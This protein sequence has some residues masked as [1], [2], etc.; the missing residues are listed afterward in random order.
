MT[1]TKKLSGKQVFPSGL[2][3]KKALSLGFLALLL[4]AGCCATLAPA[5]ATDLMTTPDYKPCGDDDDSLYKQ[6]QKANQAYI[7][8]AMFNANETYRKHNIEQG[9]LDCIITI[10]GYF[11][12]IQ[13]IL[14][15]LIGL[16]NTIAGLIMA[17]LVKIMEFACEYVVA[18]INYLLASACLPIPSLGLD[19]NFNLPGMPSTTCDG[20]SLL[21]FFQAQGTF[22][23]NLP[24]AP[25]TGGMSL[26]IDQLI[27]KK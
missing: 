16:T 4:I 12:V 17:V 1:A 25:Y 14:E 13:T 26:G 21:D 3:L 10:S 15:V 8:G 11:N 9:Y 27:K 19:L 2:R 18:G 6:M 23:T 22:S 20:I 24:Y 5:H 7:T